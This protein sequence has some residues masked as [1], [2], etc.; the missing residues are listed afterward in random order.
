MVSDVF[1]FVRLDE[2]IHG[3]RRTS[4]PAGDTNDEYLERLSTLFVRL[5]ALLAAFFHVSN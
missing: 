2:P 1:L 4:R 3:H 5:D